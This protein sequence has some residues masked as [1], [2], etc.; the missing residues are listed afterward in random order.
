MFTNKALFKYLFYSIFKSCKHV[1]DFFNLTMIRQ[2][3]M[4]VCQE[5]TR[6][7][8]ETMKVTNRRKK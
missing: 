6:K 7:S 1:C 5:Q 3:L 4:K 8:K 2:L